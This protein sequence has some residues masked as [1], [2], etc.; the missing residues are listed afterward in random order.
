VLPVDV[1]TC[2]TSRSLALGWDGSG[3]T[4]VGR[5]GAS[6]GLERMDCWIILFCL[7]LQQGTAILRQPDHNIIGSVSFA[8]GMGRITS[9]K[10]PEEN[11][12]RT[13]SV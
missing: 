3:S 7:F 10:L 1:E 8:K 11:Q 13:F 9:E 2:L 12:R 6:Q 4:S 5:K